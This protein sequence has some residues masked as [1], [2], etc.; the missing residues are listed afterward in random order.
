MS[1][2]LNLIDNVKFVVSRW[3]LTLLI[4]MIVA[5][6]AFYGIEKYQS[7]NAKYTA[8]ASFVLA[9]KENKKID[10]QD[11]L[12]GQDYS[13]TLMTTITN[14]VKNPRVIKRTL[15]E[16]DGRNAYTAAQ[17]QYM[18]TPRTQSA[19]TVST[20]SLIGYVTFKD[21]SA[22]RARNVVN[23]LVNQTKKAEKELWGTKSVR[24]LN[25]ATMPIKKNTNK[26]ITMLV[27]VVAFVV[28]FL[29]I[30]FGVLLG[31]YSKRKS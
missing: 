21:E 6:G 18:A 30:S 12:V 15:Q 7:A 27:I 19:M 13:Q 4:P 28:S 20:E 8:S 22:A 17:L 9:V 23:E 29:I 14:L 3:Y 1:N 26:R 16:V 10:I 24:V 11:S 5:G 25:K 31:R 2:V